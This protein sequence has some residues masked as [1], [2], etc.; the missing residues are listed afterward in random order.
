MITRE[1]LEAPRYYVVWYYYTTYSRG[2]VAAGRKERC[3]AKVPIK[4]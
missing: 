2:T 3:C 1:L 4:K